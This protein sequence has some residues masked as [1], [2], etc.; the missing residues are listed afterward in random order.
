[1]VRDDKD[2]P[3][4]LVFFV[5]LHNLLGLYTICAGTP[6]SPLIKFMTNKQLLRT[7]LKVIVSIYNAR[8]TTSCDLLLHKYANLLQI[9]SRQVDYQECNLNHL[10]HRTAHLPGI[11]V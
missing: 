6:S 11:D 1:M 5:V 9:F 7:W 3:N 10:Y 2:I 4:D 8:V